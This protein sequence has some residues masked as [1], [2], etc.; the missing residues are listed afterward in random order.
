[1]MPLAGVGIRLEGVNA[2]ADLAGGR[3]NLDADAAVA[4][5]GRV[6]VT[7][8]IDLQGG[9]LD[10]AILLDRVVARDPNLY[11]TEISGNLRMSGRNADGPLISGT[12]NLGETEIRIPST[13][14][15]GPPAPRR[16][17]NLI[18]AM[19]PVRRAWPGR[20][21]PRHRPRRGWI[22]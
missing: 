4:A 1:M 10:L 18:P 19:H 17:W 12:I 15:G 5:G 16:G 6:S 21:P 7:G 14:L 11:E 9:T 13:G 22:C 20:R 3:I 2:T 8:P